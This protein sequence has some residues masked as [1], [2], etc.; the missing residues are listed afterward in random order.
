MKRKRTNYQSLQLVEEMW[1]STQISRGFL[2][3][4]QQERVSDLLEL[5]ARDEI[6]LQDL[7][8]F[9]VSYF[10][11]KLDRNRPIEEYAVISDCMSAVTGVIDFE[12]VSRGMA[13]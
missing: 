3:G 5:K 7:R 10:A 2:T 11:A 8:D 6:D 13:V 4:E 1:Q 12:K 9:A